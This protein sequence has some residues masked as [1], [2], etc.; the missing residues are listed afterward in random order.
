MQV[1]NFDRP[2][3]HIC[4]VVAG[5]LLFVQTS[6]SQFADLLR[7]LFAGWQLSYEAFPNRQ[8]DVVIKCMV[9]ESFPLTPVEVQ[10]FELAEQAQC[11]LVDNGFFVDFGSSLVQLK[12]TDTVEINIWF[13]TG[14]SS[15][16]ANLARTMSFAICAGLRRYGLFELHGA[17]LLAPNGGPGVIILGPS[18]S[19]KSTLTTQLASSGWQYLSDD[20]LLLSLEHDQ[21]VSRGFRSFFALSPE[22]IALTGAT[23]A[24]STDRATKTCFEPADVFGENPVETTIPRALFFTTVTGK[25]ETRVVELSRAETMTRLLRASP[26]ATY[27]REVAAENLRVLSQLAKQST[28]FDLLAGRDLLIPGYASTLLQSITA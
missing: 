9:G 20:E 7:H 27:D 13:K 12:S 14:S 5:R 22:A 4:Y 28:G 18:G 21:V 16:N 24:S 3:N 15:V 17:G 19:G 2:V 23:I 11:Y 10:R 26:W 6:D 25:G 8:P 1:R